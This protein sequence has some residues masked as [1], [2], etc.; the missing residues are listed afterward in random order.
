MNLKSLSKDA[1]RTNKQEKFV[2]TTVQAMGFKSG[3]KAGRMVM[4]VYMLM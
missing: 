4:S 2:Q 1:V 3:L